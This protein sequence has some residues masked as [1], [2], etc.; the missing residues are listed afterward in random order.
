M[1]KLILSI[2]L[3]LTGL[4]LLP[5]TAEAGR[6]SYGQ[7][8]GRFSRNCRSCGG[9]VFTFRYLVGYARDGCPIYRWREVHQCRP[10]YSRGYES[11]GH[12]HG[13]GGGDYGHR[14]G[15]GGG[16]RDGGGRGHGGHSGH[17]HRR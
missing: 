1:N 6:G 4:T 11:Q 17:G 8:S 7:D 12:R 16:H 15:H 3:A 2:I 10:S 14:S 9:G 5:S 13:H